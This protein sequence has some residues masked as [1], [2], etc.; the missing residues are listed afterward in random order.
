[1][2]SVSSKLYAKSGQNLC[3]LPFTEFIQ[4]NEQALADPA[5][6]WGADKKHEIYA[7]TLA[8]I[9]FMTYFYRAKE[10]AMAPLAPLVPLL[11]RNCH[12]KV[13]RI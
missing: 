5:A 13:S 6:R 12:I 8:A 7:A 1:M 2:K 10:G 3:S 11:T 4:K 9:T